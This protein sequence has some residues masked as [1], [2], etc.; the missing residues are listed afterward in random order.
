MNC[1]KQHVILANDQMY[2]I[3]KVLDDKII[4]LDRLS[5][6]VKERINAEYDR[7]LT[8]A[9][10]DRDQAYAQINQLIEE[11]KQQ[12]RENNSELNQLPVNEA[13]AFARRMNSEFECINEDNNQIFCVATTLPKIQVQ[14]KR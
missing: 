11:Y 9:N 14:H 7:I 6:I 10:T 4:I 5:T 2:N 1:A 3:Q 13:S 12:I 8:Q